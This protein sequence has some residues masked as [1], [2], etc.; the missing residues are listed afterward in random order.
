MQPAADAQEQRTRAL[1]QLQQAFRDAFGG[2]NGRQLLSHSCM[3]AQQS[4][5][6]TLLPAGTCHHIYASSNMNTTSCLPG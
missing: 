4:S 2:D 5:S 1:E 6:S 3:F